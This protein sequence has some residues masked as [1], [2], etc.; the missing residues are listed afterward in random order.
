MD[1]KDVAAALDEIAAYLELRGDDA[2]RVRAYRT[3]ARAIAHFN[4]DLRTALREGTLG[5]LRGVGPTT[6]DVISDLLDTGRS[7]TLESLR[8]SI[9]PGLVAM[10]E[11]PGLGVAK[12]RQIHAALRVDSV[13]ELEAAARD[14]R[15][16]RVPRFGPRTA[17]RVLRGIQYRRQIAEVRLLH[18]ARQD[19]AELTRVLEAVEGITRVAV[20]GSLRRGSELIR[21]LD[22][23]VELRGDPAALVDRLGRLASVRESVHEQAVTLRFTSGAA[24]DV[25]WAP[26]ERFGFQL[27]TVTGNAGHLRALKAR[28]EA[29]GFTWSDDGLTHD[30]RLLPC[31]EEHD[32]YRVLALPFV[33]PELRE[34]DIEIELAAADALP[35][36]VDTADLRGFLH[37]HSNYSDGVST[38][39][40]WAEACRAAGYTYLGIT[41]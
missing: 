2:F 7:T 13:D 9:P 34:G 16:A 20:A 19:A 11:V 24:V 3:A 30:G 40:Q 8:D 38:I 26:P 10:L 37:C 27:L 21:D 29:L 28:A 12:V 33:P 14:G 22:F 32:V 36:L 6:Q 23:V 15:L 35:H 18:H 17:E 4:G 31:P 5:E 39:A 1:R 25:Y 41:D